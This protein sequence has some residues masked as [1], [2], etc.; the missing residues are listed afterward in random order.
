MWQCVSVQQGQPN[1]GNSDQQGDTLKSDRKLTRRTI[2]S[3]AVVAAVAVS[4]VLVAS[5]A[6]ADV[7]RAGG[8]A[9]AL[10]VSGELL[11]L[12]LPTVIFAE[13]RNGQGSPMDGSWDASAVSA[14]VPPVLLANGLSSHT[15]AT[16]GPGGS[17]N[18]SADVVDLTVGGLVLTGLSSEC[19]ADESGYTGS[20]SVASG[21]LF[22][23]PISVAPG[24]S[25]H[26][27]ALGTTVELEIAEHVDNSDQHSAGHDNAARL[28]ISNPTFSTLLSVVVAHSH[29]F[30][31]NRP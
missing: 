23:V 14:A 18:S 25:T 12:P 8:N 4:T 28:T 20:S 29:C 11:G 6:Q 24:A 15:D 27:V 31:R 5:P 19:T 10:S 26:V 2:R 17:S 1:S 22:G 7:K 13:L 3:L 9:W 16:S 30:S 21:T